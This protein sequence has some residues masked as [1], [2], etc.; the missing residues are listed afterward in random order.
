[1]RT[2]ATPIWN[3]VCSSTRSS[4]E[5]SK[6]G[7]PNARRA[8]S[9]RAAFSRV[10]RTQMSMSPVARGLPCGHRERPDDDVLNPGGG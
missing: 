3:T 10:G 7:A 6:S 9:T 5:R 2:G 8:E 1:M 4:I